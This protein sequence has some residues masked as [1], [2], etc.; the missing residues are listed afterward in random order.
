MTTD[1]LPMEEKIMQRL[2]SS[3]K[4]LKVQHYFCTTWKNIPKI[5]TAYSTLRVVILST[6]A[7]FDICNLLMIFFLPAIEVNKKIIYGAV[8]KGSPSIFDPHPSPPLRPIA[9]KIVDPP[10]TS[11][12]PK[13]QN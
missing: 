4:Q 3:A 9:Y 11:E 1:S 7:L 6:I 13:L 8:H 10:W 2:G 5:E 12:F